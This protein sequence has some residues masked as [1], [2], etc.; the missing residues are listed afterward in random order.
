MPVMIGA[1][2]LSQT[3]GGPLQGHFAVWGAIVP[4]DEKINA[5]LLLRDAKP[6]RVDFHNTAVVVF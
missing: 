6:P 4:H 1:T 3:L 2:S 5:D